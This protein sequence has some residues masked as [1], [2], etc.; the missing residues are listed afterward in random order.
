MEMAEGP[1]VHHY[2]RRLDSVLADKSAEV[3]F[4][5]KKL[6][7]RGDELSGAAVSRVEAL[8]KQFRIFFDTGHI[9]LVHLLMWGSWG[10]YGKDEK[11]E[12]PEKRARLILRS[13]DAVAVAF[14]APIIRL[15][16]ERES[17][18]QSRWGDSGP[19]PLREDYSRD[20]AFRS[21]RKHGDRPIG[22]VIM[23]QTVVAG[24]GNI[25]RNEILFLSEV[26]PRRKVSSLRDTKLNEI[27]S[28][29]EDLM[30]RWLQQ[31]GGKKKWSV[32]YQRSGQPCP[33][34]G[35]E[36]EFFRQNDRVTYICPH[37]QR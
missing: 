35:A 13:E 3:E 32:L 8:G 16:E 17:L 25:L 19:D 31:I 4:G 21:I 9:L 14:S 37:C 10:I 18:Q 6:R 23:D 26:H 7:G 11:W 29:T 27:L 36:I 33:Q 5:I 12:K 1:L 20:A 22:V 24:V 28:H 34:C 2:A 30:H 15:Y